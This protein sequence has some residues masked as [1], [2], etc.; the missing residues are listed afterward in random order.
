MVQRMVTHSQVRSLVNLALRIADVSSQFD[1]Y[2]M[3]G[4][5]TLEAAEVAIRKM[6]Q[7]DSDDR[8]V[9]L[10][11][12]ANLARYGIRPRHLGKSTCSLSMS[13]LFF[14]S[15]PPSTYYPRGS[16]SVLLCIG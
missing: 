16:S 9:F 4:D 15:S 14:C 10:V 13:N 12:D 8:L 1:Q 5:H 7:E 2:C 11:S 3:S 6:Q